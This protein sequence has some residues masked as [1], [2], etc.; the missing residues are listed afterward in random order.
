MQKNHC[1][2]KLLP[3]EGS[4]ISPS[5]MASLISYVELNF[6][7]IQIELLVRFQML[8]PPLPLGR[9]LAMI[10][11][12]WYPHIEGLKEASCSINLLSG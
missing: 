9:Y 12:K 5:T 7:S 11:G 8:P 6:V 1:I 2:L 3:N 10:I 4:F